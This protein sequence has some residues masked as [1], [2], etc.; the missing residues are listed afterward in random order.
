MDQRKALGYWGECLAAKYLLKNNYKYLAK[1]FKCGRLEIDLIFEENNQC[2]F[3]EVK[4]REDCHES[5]YENPLTSRQTKN[6][7]IAI[8]DYCLKN[9]INT[10]SVR[11]DLIYI[12]VNK[13]NR[14][15]TLKHFK[16]ILS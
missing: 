14:R 7:N 3:F 8:I 12:I 6:L 10:E 13:L 11:L 1:N 15:A 5:K 16:N 2:V 4:T 9:K